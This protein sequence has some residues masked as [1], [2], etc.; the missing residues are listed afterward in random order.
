MTPQSLNARPAY[1]FRIPSEVSATDAFSGV[2]LQT[3]V[4]KNRVKKSAGALKKKK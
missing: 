3:G 1:L 4:E 2:S